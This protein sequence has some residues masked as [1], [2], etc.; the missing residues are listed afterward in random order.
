[1]TSLNHMVSN[2]LARNKDFNYPAV[3]Q[4]TFSRLAESGNFVVYGANDLNSKSR[5]A[6]MVIFLPQ[7]IRLSRLAKFS[8]LNEFSL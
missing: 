2:R 6:H 7:D 1:M 3:N 5:E 8:S 4:K